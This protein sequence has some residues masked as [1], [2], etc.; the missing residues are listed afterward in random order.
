MADNV[1]I[2]DYKNILDYSQGSI[3][4]LFVDK[5]NVIPGISA[6]GIKNCSMQ[7]W[8]FKIHFPGEPVMPGVLVMEC[9]LSLGTFVIS[10]LPGYKGAR[11]LVDS[12]AVQKFY[13]GVFPGDTLELNAECLRFRHGI[14]K[15][16]GYAKIG[17]EKVC[18]VEYTL[19]VPKDLI[20]VRK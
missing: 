4:Y 7:D 13:R 2:L 18:D 1:I 6:K 15:F 11:V 14:G 3:E 20:T 12:C 16:K 19:V 17:E 10:T 5:A 9:I 8:Y